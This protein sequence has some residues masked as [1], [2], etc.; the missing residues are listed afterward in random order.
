MWKKYRGVP[1]P[2]ESTLGRGRR[3]ERGWPWRWNRG[4][5]SRTTRRPCWGRTAS[6]GRGS[7]EELSGESGRSAWLLGGSGQ[8][9]PRAEGRAAEERGGVGC[10]PRRDVTAGADLYQPGPRGVGGLM[11][12]KCER[13]GSSV[14]S[15]RRGRKERG[16]SCSSAP[17]LPAARPWPGSPPRVDGIVARWSTTSPLGFFVRP[18]R[19]VLIGWA[20][21]S[22]AAVRAAALLA[23]VQT[24]P[25]RDALTR[26]AVGLL[27]SLTATCSPFKRLEQVWKESSRQLLEASWHR[28]CT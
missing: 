1:S 14:R 27:V 17:R 8:T 9:Q 5:R 2:P 10:G 23:S 28:A 19:T 21:G 15:T 12:M 6:G 25:K 3:E 20:L 24:E 16:A 18:D 26:W 13:L 7:G 22:C 4:R 11:T